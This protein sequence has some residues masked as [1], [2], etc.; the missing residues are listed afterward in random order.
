MKCGW[1]KE[2]LKPADLGLD[3]FWDFLVFPFGGF[4]L[5]SISTRK[6]RNYFQT[7]TQLHSL[8]SSAHIRMMPA[9]SCRRPI[10]PVQGKHWSYD[11]QH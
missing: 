8:F 5:G 3:W 7:T 4:F 10:P 2:V 11:F 6:E 9:A 1:E